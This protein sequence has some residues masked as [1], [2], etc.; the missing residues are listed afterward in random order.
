VPVHVSRSATNA[1]R[2]DLLRGQRFTRS[3][4]RGPTGI[5]GILASRLG[6]RRY[7]V[8]SLWGHAPHYVSA[9]PNPQIAVRILRELVKVTGLQV[10]LESL[11]ASAARFTDQVRE[12]VSRD[13][14]AAEYVRD[15]ERQYRSSRRDEE[16]DDIGDE[17]SG[18]TDGDL[19]SGAAMVD[20]IEQFLRFGQRPP[21][22]NASSGE[23]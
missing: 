9:S 1:D 14:E 11:D 10:D 3:N 23:E 19:P 8:L 21:G 2:H 5:V 12:A 7:P 6:D 13:P 4:Y 15:L 17:D 16:E 22:S 20:A 18:P